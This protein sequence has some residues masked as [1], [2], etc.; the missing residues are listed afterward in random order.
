[1][2]ELVF[3]GLGLHDETGI[4]LRGAELARSCDIL[5]AEFYANTMTGLNLA[6][7]ERIVGKKVT[8][9]SR[10]Q[11][12][13]ESIIPS[14]AKTHRV[15]FLVP[16]DPLVATTHV[17]LRLRAEKN[18]VKTS[19]IHA[20][21]ISSAIAGTT[22]LQSYKFGRTVTIPTT[23]NETF[24]KSVYT[25][26]RGNETLG[27][28]T[29]ILLEIDVEGKRNITIQQAINALLNYA[30]KNARNE[31]NSKTFAIGLARLEAP[32]MLIKA[33]TLDELIRTDFG[34]PPHVLIITGRLH[35]VETEALEV[36]CGASRESINERTK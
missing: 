6:N 9:L 28:H 33:G 35:F 15:G 20:A 30:S 29:L 7:L 2:G 5:Y 16:G 36:L 25:A 32:D 3:I 21:S 17:D 11:V 34:N 1:V 22:G 14:A 4:S 27:L 26:I 8:V 19:I 13:E 10:S 12:E 18:N 31:L 24:P 23:A